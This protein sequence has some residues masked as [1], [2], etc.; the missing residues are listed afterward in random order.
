M[1]LV[2]TFLLET[3]LTFLSTYVFTE[4]TQNRGAELEV[5]AQSGLLSSAGCHGAM[6][7][8]KGFSGLK[9]MLGIFRAHADS[10]CFSKAL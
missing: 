2:F 5:T 10:S 7:A 6:W 1:Y 9:A 8:R 3:C 4:C